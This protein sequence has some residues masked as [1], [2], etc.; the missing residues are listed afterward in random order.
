M[1]PKRRRRR[2]LCCRNLFVPDPRNRHH[3]RFCSAELC[4][5]A[6]K[7]LSQKRWLAKPDNKDQW[8]GTAHGQRVRTWREAHPQ[9]WKRPGKIEAI[10]LQEICSTQP[11]VPEELKLDLARR[12]LQDDC[13]AQHPLLVGLISMLTASTLQEDIALTH[14]RLVAK[15][16]EI[17]G[18][19][20][21]TQITK[22]DEQKT[23][24]AGARAPDPQPV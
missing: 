2:C 10:A 21:I 9:Y 17:L 16:H 13:L 24:G 3:Q 4:Q 14:R 12:P 15:G 7:A 22:Y 6:S 19:T 20:P 1:K 5:A 8:R 18:L 23:P 11:L